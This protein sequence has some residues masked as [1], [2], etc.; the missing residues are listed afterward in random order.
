MSVSTLDALA[1][2]STTSNRALADAKPQ[3]KPAGPA[4]TAL[5]FNDHGAASVSFHSNEHRSGPVFGNAQP[6]IER[7][8]P[9]QHSAFMPLSLLDR[10]REWMA[11]LFAGHRPSMRPG[12]GNPPPRPNPGWSNPPPRPN[13]TVGKPCPTRPCESDAD[14]SL[15]SRKQL[16]GLMRDNFPAFQ[17]PRYP[18]YLSVDSLKA[19]AN[20]PLL[21]EYGPNKEENKKKNQETLLARQVLKD[22]KLM[23]AIFRNPV[24]G[25][26]ERLASPQRLDMLAKRE[27][28]FTYY[29]EKQLRQEV[30]EHWGRNPR[31]EVLQRSANRPLTGDSD[32]DHQTLLAREL[33]F[34][35]SD[36]VAELF[37][38]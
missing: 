25:A 6:A 14:Y 38:K 27:D 15:K 13:P 10:L 28:Y 17:D 21:P 18:G 36:L 19:K 11:S 32:K 16:M 33:L 24:T 20:R 23:D 4:P 35:R 2:A 8:F 30:R 37:K 7:H 34:L 31:I 3:A 1:S 12:C 22:P 9:G 5:S 26:R 29:S